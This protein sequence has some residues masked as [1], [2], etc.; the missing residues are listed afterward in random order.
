MTRP[1]PWPRRRGFT[2]IEL[3]VVIAIIAVLIGLLLPAVQKA[4]EAA[5]RTQT[6]N[7]LKQIGLGCQLFHDSNNR[8]ALNGDNSNPPYSWSWAFV[9]LPYIEQ[10]DLY[11]A[12]V[13]GP[14]ALATYQAMGIKTYQCPGRSHTAY[15]TAA[16]YNNNNTG[17]NPNYSTNFNYNGP[18]TD[19]AINAFTFSGYNNGPKVAPNSYKVTLAT[20]TAGNGSS[21]TVLAGEKAMD[22]QKYG[23]LDDD[24]IPTTSPTA[25]WDTVIYSGGGGGTGRSG[26]GII[27]DAVGIAYPNMWGSPFSGGCPFVLCDGSVHLTTYSASGSADFANSLNYKSGV[28]INQDTFGW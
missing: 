2:L 8:M 20:I 24:P 15:S 10:K 23:N 5:A 19:Y 4:R 14:A 6:I 9:I 1:N 17:G 16:T 18:H 12:A 7:N 21:N 22:P 25:W 11:N 26:S 3:L 28:P 27:Q 13:A